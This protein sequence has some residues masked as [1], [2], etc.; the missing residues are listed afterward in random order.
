MSH[1]EGKDI[2]G[3]M[4]LVHYRLAKL[5]ILIPVLHNSRCCSWY[6]SLSRVYFLCQNAMHEILNIGSSVLVRYLCEEWFCQKNE[7]N[8]K[9]I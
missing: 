8:G 5:E 7:K 1:S 9:Q 2:V 6:V 3:F 4:P